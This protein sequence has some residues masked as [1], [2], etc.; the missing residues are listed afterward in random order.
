MREQARAEEVATDSIEYVDDNLLL[1][2]AYT[3][4]GMMVILQERG[5]AVIENGQRVS[6][7]ESQARKCACIV[8]SLQIPKVGKT[9]V[10]D[11]EKYKLAHVWCEDCRSMFKTRRGLKQHMPHCVAIDAIWEDPS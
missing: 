7:L 6:G 8:F 3:R 2:V 4:E 1:Q 11:V 10:Q 5:R 9:T